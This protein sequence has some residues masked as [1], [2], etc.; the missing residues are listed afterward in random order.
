MNIITLENISKNYSDKILL[1]NVSLGINDG[2]KIGL[3]GING[4]GKSTFLK[5][6]SGREEFFDGNI[7]KGKNVR[8]EY[9]DQNPLFDEDATVLEQIFKGDTKEM[10]LLK[11]YEELLDKINSCSGENFDSLNNELLKVQ[12]EIDSLSLWDME[13]D[14]KTILNKL[15]IKNYSEKVGNLSG[16]QKKRIALACSLITPCDLL[17]LDEPTNHLDSDSIEWLEEF[18]NSRK[19]ALLMITHDRYFLDRV[20]NR[21]I[22]LDRGNLYTYPGNYT[23][24]LEKKIERIEVEQSQ[25][26]KKNALIRN[27]LKWVRRGAKARTTK[28]KARLQRFDELVSEESIKRQEDVDISF[29]GSR[30]GKKVVELYDISKSFGNKVIIKDFN[31]IFL[32][33]DRIGIIGENGAGKTTLVNILRNKLPID[34]GKIEIGDTVKIGCFAQDNSNMDPKLRVIDYVKEGGEYIPVEDGTK[35]M[36]STMCERFLFDSTMQYTP[37]EKLSG[38]ERRRLHLLRVLM[39][40]PNFLILDEPTNDLD[41][42]TLKILEDF[43]DKFMGVIIVVSHDRY[44]LDRICTKIFS[45]EGNGYIKEYNGNYSDFLISKEIEKIKS[46]ESSEKSSNEFAADKGKGVKEKTKD[47]KPKFTF[48]EQKEY[49]TIDED[50]AKLE[51]KINSLEKE[52]AKNSSNYGKLNELMHEKEDV[53]SELDNKYER[54]EYLN[55]IAEAIEEFKNNN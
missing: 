37:I 6:V 14:A 21:I 4:A 48:K 45:Y 17:I 15:G 30:L 9:L 51:E 7:V 3:I 46:V 32:R 47:N 54:W 43:L 11:R 23:A 1:N 24:F 16:G 53:Q 35:I 42:E 18:L 19:G 41:I 27:E 20:T 49:E 26:E 33:N 38:G 44:F 31:Y 50:I 29:V 12:S 10:K 52:M 5:V 2:D 40:S 13:S 39:E 22:E 36:A 28:Q 55:E 34:S 25:E 8:I